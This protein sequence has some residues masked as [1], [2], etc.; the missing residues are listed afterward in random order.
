MHSLKTPLDRIPLDISLGDMA[1]TPACIVDQVSATL[2]EV[3]DRR[4]KDVEDVYQRR[5]TELEAHVR[6]RDRRIED[7][8]ELLYLKDDA[9]KSLL[10][11]LKESGAMLDQLRHDNMLLQREKDQLQQDIDDLEQR[12]EPMPCG[13]PELTR[14]A[15]DQ[16]RRWDSDARVIEQKK[17]IGRLR[18]KVEVL[19]ASPITMGE[20]W[21]RF[22]EKNLVESESEES[23]MPD[24]DPTETIF[25]FMRRLIIEIQEAED[26]QEGG[27]QFSV[28]LPRIDPVFG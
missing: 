7:F 1:S 28:L 17:E 12:P 8:Q 24:Y 26:E 11:S 9:V 16:A 3:F 22:E 6:H 13:M 4:M 19:K 14:V 23:L 10:L 21:E 2:K 5:V 25:A 27:F 18:E 15:L 20:F